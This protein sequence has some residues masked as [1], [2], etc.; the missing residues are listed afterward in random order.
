[1]KWI[2]GIVAGI[3][4][5]IALFLSSCSKREAVTLCL[6]NNLESSH[7]TSIALEWFADEV[8]KRTDGRVCVDV[9]HDGELGDSITCLEQMQYGGIDIVKADLSVM[10]NF[11]PQYQVFV[12][13]YIYQD[14]EHCWAVQDGPVGMDLLRGREM[15]EQQFYGLTYYDAG[16][17]CFFNSRK[18]IYTPKDMK[19]MLVRV[20]PSRP[21]MDMV[22]A[23]GAMYVPLSYEELYPELDNGGVIAAEN[24]IV[25]YRNASFY[26]VAPYFLDDRHT[27]SADLLVMSEK[28]RKRLSEKDL[29]IIDEVA[30]ESGRYQRE[31]WLASEEEAKQ[32]LL[33]QGVT[34][35]EP[36]EEELALFRE[37]CEP[38]WYD[39]DH[40]AYNDLL[41]RIVAAG[42]VSR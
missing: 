3:I 20:Q 31:L 2:R 34:I 42:R 19:G 24:S 32:D 39:L 15:Q 38:I 12:L 17:R 33:E 22:E 37:A 27:R 35:V 28:A 7:C 1:M 18:P 4:F 40:G 21:M 16:A 30:L 25:N 9:H 23:L 6:S 11:V 10:S 8:R 36:T 13:P 26:K 5:T 29:D 41:D 14:Q